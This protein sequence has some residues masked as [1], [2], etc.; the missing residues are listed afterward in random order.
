VCLNTVD[1]HRHWYQTFRLQLT[2]ELRNVW[3]VR[4]NMLAVQKNTHDGG[5]YTMQGAFLLVPVAILPSSS[6]SSSKLG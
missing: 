2:Y 4:D 3:L 6:G 1:E 5:I